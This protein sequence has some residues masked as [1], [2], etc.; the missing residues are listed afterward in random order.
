MH[1]AVLRTRGNSALCDR[2]ALVEQRSEQERTASDV[3]VRPRM[4]TSPSRKEATIMEHQQTMANGINLHVVQDGSSIGRFVVLLH[5]FP[6]FWHSWR[7]Q[8]PH[9]AAPGYRVWEAVNRIKQ[10]VEEHR[11]L[12]CFPDKRLTVT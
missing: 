5:G 3:T 9:L 6:E 2:L 12:R 8:I 10:A 1:L 4:A 7:R 11:Y